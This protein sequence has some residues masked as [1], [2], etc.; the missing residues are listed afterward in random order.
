MVGKNPAGLHQITDLRQRV[1][2]TISLTVL[3]IAIFQGEVLVAKALGFS[4]TAEMFKS[5]PTLSQR[6]IAALLGPFIHQGPA[7]LIGNLGVLLL[8]GGYLEFQ[9]GQRPFYVFFL[10][11]GYLAAWVP[12]AMGFTGAVGASGVAF[13]LSMWLLV[14]SISKLLKM[15]WDTEIDRRIFHIVFVFY[16]L[17]KA[18]AVL[19]DFQA[20]NNTGDLTHVFGAM[21]GLVFG[22]WFVLRYHG[23]SPKNWI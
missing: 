1:I 5:L 17:V 16:G 23:H 7:H 3:L 20:M 13:G 22:F 2:G 18:D 11:V 21:F 14:H 8:A 6:L 9:Y 15:G 19:E 12:L 4:S 10:V